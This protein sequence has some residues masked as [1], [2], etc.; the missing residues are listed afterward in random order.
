MELL[1]VRLAR[2]GIG[3]AVGGFRARERLIDLLLLGRADVQPA[4]RRAKAVVVAMAPGVRAGGR[5]PRDG[6]RDGARTGRRREQ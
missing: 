2:R 4:K 1:H 3:V 6:G 5:R